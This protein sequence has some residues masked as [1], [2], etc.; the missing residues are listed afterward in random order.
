MDADKVIGHLA[1]SPCPRRVHRT[2]GG[3]EQEEE[4]WSCG[5][6]WRVDQEGQEGGGPVVR[7]DIFLFSVCSP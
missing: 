6:D 3:I 2:G 7:V 1:D 5:S 4:V